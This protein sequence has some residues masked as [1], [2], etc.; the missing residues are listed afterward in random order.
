MKKIILL[1]LLGLTLSGCFLRVHKAD[2]EQGNIITQENVSRLH[3]GMSESQVKDIM[4]NPVLTDILSTNR[5]EYV[6]TFQKGYGTMTETRVVLIFQGG[7][8][9]EIQR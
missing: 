6:Y 2:I 7:R 8:L 3:L 9:Q 1:I 4:G 5:I